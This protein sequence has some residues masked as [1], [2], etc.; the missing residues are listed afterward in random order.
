LKIAYTIN[1]LIG[2][3]VGKNS[4]QN[5]KSDRVLILKYISDILDK[6]I[7]SANDV[8]FFLFSW[9]LDMENEFNTLLKPVKMKLEE[10]INFDIPQHLKHGNVNRVIA[11][12]SRWYGFKQVMDMVFDY[13]TQNKFKYD[14]VVSSRF[15]ICWNTPFSFSK[16]DTNQFHIPIHPDWTDYGWPGNSPEILDHVFA[17]NSTWMKEYSSM[18]DFLDEYTLPG[19]CPQW[20]TISNHF[21]MVWHLNKLGILSEDIVKKTFTNWHEKNPIIATDDTSV[22]YDIFRYRQLSKEDLF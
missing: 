3:F 20:N 12:K 17:S 5:D 7:C 13:E 2:G 14:M 4:I 10:Q 18:F 1:G 21:L 6:N 22:D 9:H 19:Q 8:D 15:D 16:L 11:H